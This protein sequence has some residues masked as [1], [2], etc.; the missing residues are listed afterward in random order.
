MNTKS[1]NKKN[2][3]EAMGE[4]DVKYI[5]KAMNYRPKRKK[6]G[7]VK[8]ISVAACFALAAVLSIGAFEGEWFRGDDTVIL[9][10]GDK[11]IFARSNA[12]AGQLS[13]ALNITARALTEEETR[14]LFAD[15]PVTADA[16]F[17][18]DKDTGNIQGLLG[19][20][21]KIG[22]IK[23]VIS[24]THVTLLDTKVC[25]T[26]EN[27]EVNGVPVT[28]GYFITKPNSRGQRTTIYYA[29]FQLGGSTVYVENAGTEAER[30]AV[31]KELAAVIQRLTDLGSLDLYSVRMG[32]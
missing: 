21:G 9:E 16:I 14:A 19:F 24:T 10:N 3:S 8:W 18:S 23:L 5:E 7:W 31:K 27:T 2:F 11:L 32:R 15:L 1:L 12:I 29:A 30:E 22:K 20:E 17:E 25:G 4:I 26:E 6:Y 28:A 13:L